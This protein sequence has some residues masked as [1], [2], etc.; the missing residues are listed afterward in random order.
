MV[1]DG[2]LLQIL[3][4]AFSHFYFY[5]LFNGSSIQRRVAGIHYYYSVLVI[6]KY[7]SDLLNINGIWSRLVADF[8]FRIFALFYFILF[9][10]IIFW[11]QASSNTQQRAMAFVPFLPPTYASTRLLL[12]VQ[13]RLV[14]TWFLGLDH[15]SALYLE[16]RTICRNRPC[17]VAR[18]R[19]PLCPFSSDQPPS[20]WWL[21]FMLTV[22]GPSGCGNIHLSL[23]MHR[24]KAHWQKWLYCTGLIQQRYRLDSSCTCSFT[25]RNSH[26]RSMPPR[27]LW[28]RTRNLRPNRA[29][30]FSGFLF[31][32]ICQ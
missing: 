24:Y 22:D 17:L 26:G 12:S 10:F 29:V 30:I 1:F 4:F 15:I 8:I 5:F 32:Q 23:V 18:P 11:P 27:L 14:L 2:V 31:H 7:A 20:I 19:C 25:T 16:V 9:Y 28:N 13:I 6:G 21:L 3:Y